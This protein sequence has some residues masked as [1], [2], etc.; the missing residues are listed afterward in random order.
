MTE[1]VVNADDLDSRFLRN[2]LRQPGGSAIQKCFQCGQCVAS[3][4]IRPIYAEFNPRRIIKRTLLGMKKLVFEDRF[5]WFCSICFLC[6]E[7]CPQ[8]VKPPEVMNA[9]KNLAV[10]EGFIPP[11]IEKLLEAYK[12]IGRLYPIDE[13][14]A[15]EREMLDLPKLA[16]EVE[17]V[18]KILG[19]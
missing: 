14:V 6:Q 16:E 2:V 10:K 8:D 18:K 11:S 13:L 4:P 7:R 3:C 9:I 19:E 5:V 1:V 15:E 17:F 12:K